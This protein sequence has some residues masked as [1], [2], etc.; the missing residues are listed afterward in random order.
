M[1][2]LT[3]RNGVALIA[4]LSILLVL[5]L[6]LPLMFTMS[7]NAMEAAMTGTDEQRASYLARSMI[8]FTV[9]AFQGVYDDAEED[10]AN[11]YQIPDDP[12]K[13]TDDLKGTALYKL[14]QFYKV[15]KALDVSVMYMYKN[16]AVEYPSVVSTPE[17]KPGE[18]DADYRKRCLNAY[19]DYMEAGIIYST[20][21]PAGY[22]EADALSGNVPER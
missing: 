13:V 17:R 4:V 6:L 22:T 10:E 11:G 2:I 15:S 19:K 8:E 20:T 14:D 18:S 5:T 3:K 1:D 16:T 21:V 9:G 7:E 12:S